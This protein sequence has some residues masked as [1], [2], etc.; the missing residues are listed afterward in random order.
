[1]LAI[2]HFE[3]GKKVLQTIE[4]LGGTLPEDLPTATKSIQQLQREEH[5]QLEQKPQPSLFDQGEP[6]KTE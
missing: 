5:K 2:S 1:M 4:E 3:V 6:E